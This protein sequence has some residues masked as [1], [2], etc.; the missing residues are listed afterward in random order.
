MHSV[1]YEVVF[2]YVLLQPG[3]L[4]FSDIS[5]IERLNRDALITIYIGRKRYTRDTIANR[6][7]FNYNKLHRD[8][9]NLHTILLSLLLFIKKKIDFKICCVYQN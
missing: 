8:R 6:F 5:D 7:K 3:N 4:R 1:N 9:T 2:N